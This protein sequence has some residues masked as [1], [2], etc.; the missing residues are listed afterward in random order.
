[1]A[2]GEHLWRNAELVEQ[3]ANP[4]PTSD[5][6][7][8]APALDPAQPCEFRLQFFNQIP[9]CGVLLLQI[10]RFASIA[11]KLILRFCGRDEL[12]NE[13]HLGVALLILKMH[14]AGR[15]VPIEDY[16]FIGPELLLPFVVHIPPIAVLAGE[17]NARFK[18]MESAVK[19]QGH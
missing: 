13:F 1:M 4:R 8:T 12:A 2:L 11:G 16:A 18:I 5:T 3:R 7:Q 14:G 17:R 6:L 19:F 15:L 9:E 10:G